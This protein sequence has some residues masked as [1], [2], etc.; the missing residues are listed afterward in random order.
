MKRSSLGLT[1][2]SLCTIP[3]VRGAQ[4]GVIKGG[5]SYGSVP[6]NSGVVPGKSS[7]ISGYAVGFAASSGSSMG[8]GVEG[9]YEQRGFT[10]SAAGYS[11]KLGYVGGMSSLNRG[12]AGSAGNFQARAMMLLADIGF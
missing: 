11:Q 1:V 5:L 2:L 12:T 10:S 8:F 9:L 7:A 6:N 4:G 3:L